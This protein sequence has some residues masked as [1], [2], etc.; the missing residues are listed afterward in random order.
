MNRFRG[1]L[2][3]G[4]VI[5]GVLLFGAG[6]FLIGDRRL[7]FDRQ[8][9]I[10]S[11]FGKVTGLQVGTRVRLAGLDAGEV[12]EIQIPSRPSDR[13]TAFDVPMRMN[14]THGTKMKNGI[15]NTSSHNATM[16]PAPRCSRY[17]DPA[18]P[19]AGMA[20][21]TTASPPSASADDNCPSPIPA[22]EIC[23]SASGRPDPRSI[24]LCISSE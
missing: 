13:F 20:R 3:G 11:T 7:L 21:P 23:D 18:S 6:L 10:N 12:L 9:E 2:V 1:A 5:G 16:G 14:M 19:S 24:A 4:F 17:P 15:T 8:F 22:P